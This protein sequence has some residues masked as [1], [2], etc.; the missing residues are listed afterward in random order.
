[1]TSIQA[2]PE[3]LTSPAAVQLLSELDADLDD[4]YGDG[5]QVDAEPSQFEPP[6]GVFFVVYVDGEPQACAGYRRHDATTAELKRM[7]VRPT[8]R[9]RGLARRLLAEL[10]T[11]AAAAGYEQMWLETG[12]PQHEAMSLYSGSGYEGIEPFGQ[13]AGFP[14]QRCYGKKLG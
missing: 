6:D 3:P 13:F 12:L 10:E 8:G 9:R 4:R 14:Q 1:M 7:F 2:R 5:E 11:H